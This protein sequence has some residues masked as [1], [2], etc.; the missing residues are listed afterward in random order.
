MKF[1]PAIIASRFAQVLA[2]LVVP[3]FVAVGCHASAR[4]QTAP[5]AATSTAPVASTPPPPPPDADADGI[6]DADDKCPNEKGVANAEHPERNGC[7]E[8]LK[9]VRLVAMKV[10]I[11]ERIMFG[12]GASTIETASDSLLEEIAQLIQGEGKGIDLIEVA[13]H[14]DK[15]GDA[16]YNVKLTQERANAV[17]A[18][19]VKR[20]VPAAKL[21]AKGYG[22]YCPLDVNDNDKNRRVEFVILKVGGKATGAALGCDAAV[23]AGVKPAAV[24]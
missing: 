20:G 1:Q 23:K 5:P 10:E 18:A 15:D 21:R 2:V 6:A 17:V 16:N 8:R 13:G 7:P 4:I 14:A 9:R 3:A 24:P 19:L 12:S 11:G 22:F